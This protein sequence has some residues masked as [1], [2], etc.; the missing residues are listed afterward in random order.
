LI[1]QKLTSSSSTR[2]KDLVKD[3][4]DKL[5]VV[6]TFLAMLELVRRYRISAIQDTLFGEI[7]IERAGEWN[8]DLDFDIEFA[9]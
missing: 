5:S 4:P 6:V 3:S 1:A 2:F 9:E 8:D 7:E